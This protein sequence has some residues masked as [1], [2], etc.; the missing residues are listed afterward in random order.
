MVWTAA[1]RPTRGPLATATTLTPLP[2]LIHDFASRF[3]TA[4]PPF[5]GAVTTTLVAW[6]ES[7][8]CSRRS[9]AR[10]GRASS[11]RATG[12]EPLLFVHGWPA[13][14]RVFW[15]LLTAPPLRARFRML[16]PDLFGFGRSTL[17][18][19]RRLTFA[20]EVRRGAG[21]GAAGGRAVPGGRDVVR[22]ARAAAGG[23]GRP[24]AVPAG[25]AA[26][27]VPSPRSHRRQRRGAA[28]RPLSAPAPRVAPPA[29]VAG[30]PACGPPSP[31]WSP[32]ARRRRGRG[33]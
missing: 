17:R 3:V 6:M 13:C 22:R 32:A 27:A 10:A 28:A 26:G 12:H 21:G 30:R 23:D 33:R 15:P 1:E 9:R 5:S 29:P 25:G 14:A 16:A 20:H 24:G 31:A 4:V 8:R 19:P 11:S 2:R 7:R 18:A